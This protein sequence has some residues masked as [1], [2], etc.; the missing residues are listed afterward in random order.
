MINTLVKLSNNIPGYILYMA[1]SLD[2]KPCHGSNPLQSSSSM[3][4]PDL[5]PDAKT[6]GVEVP[7]LPVCPRQH[8]PHCFQHLDAAGGGAA[9]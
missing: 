9:P 4:C 3:L 2:L 7:D 5:Q 6:R 1:Q 8:G